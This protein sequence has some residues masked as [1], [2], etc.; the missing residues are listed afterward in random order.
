MQYVSY[1][2]RTVLVVVVMALSILWG[3]VSAWAAP[4]PDLWDH[5][6]PHTE[7]MDPANA[8]DH[9]AWAA[10]LATYHEFSADGIARI[11][12]AAVTE[13]DKQS[14]S[15]YLTDMQAVD[16][17]A[18]D[19]DHQFAYWVNVY[20]S[21]A[22]ALILEHFPVDSIRDIRFG[23]L[24]FGPWKEKLLEIDGEELSLDDVEHRIL[25]PIWNDPRI[26]YAVNCAALGCP[27][28]LG[29]PLEAG[30]YDAQLDVAAR[31]FVNHSRAF[32]VEGDRLYAS[33]I[34]DW[35]QEDFE[36]SEAGVIRHAL[37]YAE[38]ELAEI[39]NG[40]SDIRGYEYDWALNIQN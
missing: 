2:G 40:I 4:E 26:H 33:K 12:Y 23:F 14:L 16:V 19:R 34:Y 22:V 9:S 30:T 15:Q 10:F 38:P 29:E 5:W 39:L 35:F 11:D 13:A 32:W 18:L 6:L 20:N 37:Q 28:L 31:Q 7:T 25:R 27:N 17:A 24:S 21:Q 8:P 36:D 3:T 1:M